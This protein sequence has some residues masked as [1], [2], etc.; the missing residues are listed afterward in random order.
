MRGWWMAV[1]GVVV[2]AGCSAAPAK[3]DPGVAPQ[4]QV[5][6]KVADPHSQLGAIAGVVVDDAIRPV[7]DASVQ[8][9][10]QSGNLTTGAN[11]TFAV[12]DLAPGVY[13]V[14]VHAPHFLPVQTSAEVRA[15]Q[16][17][18]VR[19]L[20]P[21]DNRPE[22]YHQTMKFD[23][24]IQA[25]VGIVTY[26]TDLLANDTGVSMCTCTLYFRN[27]P[28]LQTIVYEAVWTETTPPPTGPSKFYWEV[29]EVNASHIE[30]SY[31]NSPILK[32]LPATEWANTTAMQ[33]RLTGPA[34]WVET[35]QAYE[36]FVTLFYL[37][38]APDDWSF[39]QGD[40]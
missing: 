38:P 30:S 21:S 26:A 20:L 39:V 31:E 11:G 28:T 12:K 17:T 7:K 33:A 37:T 29:E 34:E 3:Q 6:E 15:G 40:A 24:F 22:P 10:G 36:M 1:L 8:V 18:T 25:S 27:D 9:Q 23:G 5:P 19:V 4:L 13:F 35:N 2:L 32:H 16:A 14:S